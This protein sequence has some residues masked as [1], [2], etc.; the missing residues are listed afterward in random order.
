[1]NYMRRRNI[2]QTEE[3]HFA[4]T[5]QAIRKSFHEVLLVMKILETKP[6][7]ESI[8]L[9]YYDLYCSVNKSLVEKEN[10]ANNEISDYSFQAF[11][12]T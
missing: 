12:P 4:Q 5:A 8:Y 9:N 7:V 2:F 10:Y 6:H 11:Y 1:M 3:G